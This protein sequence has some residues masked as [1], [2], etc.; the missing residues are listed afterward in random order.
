[1]FM[2]FSIKGN[3]AVLIVYVDDISLTGDDVMEMNMLKKSLASEFVIKD[4]GLLRYFLGMEV[5][6]SKKRIVVSQW[7]YIL[8][9]LR[10]T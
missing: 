5:A 9:L 8:D 7:K 6:R 3:I 1:M 10:E 2:K 4:L